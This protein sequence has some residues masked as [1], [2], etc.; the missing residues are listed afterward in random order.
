MS[1]SLVVTGS[2]IDRRRFFRKVGHIGGIARKKAAVYA[3]D[4]WMILPP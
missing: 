1:T 3:S 2:G 4:G